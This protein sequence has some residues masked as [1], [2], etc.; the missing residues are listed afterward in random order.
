MAL[1]ACPACQREVSPSAI[2]CP[3]CGH[4]IAQAPQT[5]QVEPTEAYKKE[6]RDREK[7]AAAAQLGAQLG[8]SC[9]G[10][11]LLSVLGMLLAL[12]ALTGCESSQH[13]DGGSQGKA[14]TT[15]VVRNERDDSD[16]IRIVGRRDGT[17]AQPD[18][19]T[20]PSA[21]RIQELEA[22]ARTPRSAEERARDAAM[23]RNRAS[24]IEERKKLAW[25]MCQEFVSDRIK[26]PSTAAY[27]KISVD[28]LGDRTFRCVG[29]VESQIALGGRTGETFVCQITCTD[30]EKGLWH[31]DSLEFSR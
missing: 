29:N 8:S 2:A 18:P 30:L 26:A 7:A 12:A 22:K 24:A 14:G 21:E 1:I 25:L 19:R 28:A 31:L 6:L 27:R 11:V 9:F 10:T 16:E 4:P 17:N 20:K 3:G 15:Y 5:V 13:N 23:E